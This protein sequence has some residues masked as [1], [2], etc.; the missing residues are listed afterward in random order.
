MICL[1]LAVQPGSFPKSEDGAQHCN[2]MQTV[3]TDYTGLMRQ[4]NCSLQ[5]FGCMNGFG[6][7]RQWQQRTN[8]QMHK[9]SSLAPVHCTYHVFFKFT[10]SWMLSCWFRSPSLSFRWLKRTAALTKSFSSVKLETHYTD[11]RTALLST[12]S[13]SCSWSVCNNCS[14]SI[15]LFLSATFL[16]S[17]GWWQHRFSSR[18]SVHVTWSW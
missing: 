9:C 16:F 10:L 17:I 7:R 6:Q 18:K 3:R 12:C 1:F 13:H 15:S 4:I 2:S 11:S 8:G 14:D 5:T